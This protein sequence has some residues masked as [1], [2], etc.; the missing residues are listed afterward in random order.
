MLTFIAWGDWENSDAM[1]K[2]KMQSI[3]WGDG[4][5]ENYYMLDS[6]H[7]WVYR[8]GKK[9]KLNFLKG[10]IVNIGLEI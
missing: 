8:D 1:R 6:M 4:K 7:I 10:V 9:F 2:F 3:F 5:G